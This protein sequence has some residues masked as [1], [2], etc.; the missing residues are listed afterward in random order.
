VLIAQIFDKNNVLDGNGDVLTD[1]N[2]STPIEL[3]GIN[4]VIQTSTDV[5]QV[6][7]A[8]GTIQTSMPDPGGYQV[9]YGTLTSTGS[10]G[11]SSRV[12][13]R[14]RTQKRAIP[15][16]DVAVIMARSDSTGTINADTQLDQDW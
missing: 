1:A 11:S 12:S 15:N 14:A 5:E 2:Y 4:S 13:T 7:D 16:G 3:S 8:T 6:P 10:Q 9:G